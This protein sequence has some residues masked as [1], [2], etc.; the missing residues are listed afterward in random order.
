[1][2]ASLPEGSPELQH[3]GAP[4]DSHALFDRLPANVIE[5]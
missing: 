2:E 4:P 3:S 5:R 1:M